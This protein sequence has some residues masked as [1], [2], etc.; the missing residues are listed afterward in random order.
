MNWQTV[1]ANLCERGRYDNEEHAPASKSVLCGPKC[2]VN[3]GDVS[4]DGLKDCYNRNEK[5]SCLKDG[6]KCQWR[7]E[8]SS[9]NSSSNKQ[10]DNAAEGNAQ[11]EGHCEAGL[12]GTKYTDVCPKNTDKDSCEKGQCASERGTG[13]C[14]N[15]TPNSY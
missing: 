4:P 15:W 2:S 8:S 1:Y 6:N 11:A 3:F 10:A 14:C 12:G 5:S 13:P 7:D 9:N